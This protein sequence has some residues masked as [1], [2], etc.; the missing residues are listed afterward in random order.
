MLDPAAAC[1]E[2][3]DSTAPARRCGRAPGMLVPEMGVGLEVRQVSWTERWSRRADVFPEQT[4][5]RESQA[6]VGVCAECLPPFP[7]SS[8]RLSSA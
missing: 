5:R 6:R 4:P 3:R 2:S 7:P 8:C 1:C